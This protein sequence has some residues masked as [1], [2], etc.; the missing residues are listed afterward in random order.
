MSVQFPELDRAPGDRYR[1]LAHKTYYV[2]TGVCEYGLAMAKAPPTPAQAIRAN[3]PHPDRPA[4]ELE[5]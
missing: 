1:C 2:L 4:F 5:S 3:I